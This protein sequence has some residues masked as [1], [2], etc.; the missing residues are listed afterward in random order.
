M[1]RPNRRPTAT[2]TIVI[3]A[4][5]AGRIKAG[6]PTEWATATAV[7]TVITIIAFAA[8]S[9]YVLGLTFT[10]SG[11]A[12][13]IYFSPTDYLRIAPAWAIPALGTVLGLLGVIFVVQVLGP[14]VLASWF[15]EPA[16]IDEITKFIQ[17]V[18]EGQGGKA[19]QDGKRGGLPI[20][21]ILVVVAFVVTFRLGMDNALGVGAVVTFLLMVLLLVLAIVAYV[22]P[23]RG[24]WLR[25]AWLCVLFIWLTALAFFFG[26]WY[27]P[28][29]IK[30]GPL[31]QIL[32][33]SEKDRIAAVEGRVIFDLD[34]YLLM[35]IDDK[36]PVSIPHDSFLDRLTRLTQ[37]PQ[38]RGH[39]VA[40][41]HEKIRLIQTP[42]LP[43]TSPTPAVASPT[44]KETSPVSPSPLQ[45]PTATAE[46][47]KK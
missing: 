41:P 4:T 1:N 6:K 40:I 35:L 42:P 37:A 2:P 47:Q 34:R 18:R 7:V 45:S 15:N 3:Q 9:I 33:E 14:L 26:N 39:V 31:S 20:F 8:S 43:A 46:P 5:A 30:E 23:I 12:L 13:A 16:T 25:I 28:Y 38:L 29:A 27:A 10:L 11:P 19:L 44:P 36:S 22:L 21:A 17:K 32:Y 24:A